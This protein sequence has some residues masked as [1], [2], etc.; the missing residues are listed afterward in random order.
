MEASPCA[1]IVSSHTASLL[2]SLNLQRQRSQFCDCVVRQ[3]QSPGQLYPA[4]RCVLAAS[5]PVLSSILSSSGALVELQAPCLTGSVLALLLDYIYTGTLPFSRIQQYYYSLLT[6]ACYLQMDELQEALRAWQKTKAKHVVSEVDKEVQKDQF[7]SAGTETWQKSTEEELQRRVEGKRKSSSPSSSSPHPY[8]E[9]V[10]VIRHSSRADMHQLAEVPP[11]QIPMGN[12]IR[13]T[14]SSKHHS[15]YLG[16][17]SVPQNKMCGE[18]IRGGKHKAELSFD[19]LPSKHQQLDWSDGHNVSTT[20]AAEETV[21]QDLRD[22]APLPV[23]MSDTGSG[24]QGEANDKQ[25]YSSRAPARVDRQKLHCNLYEARKDWF[26]TLRR[27]Q[28]S[29]HDTASARQENGSDR[30]K[31]ATAAVEN[32]PGRLIDFERRASLELSE[33]TEPRSTFTKPGDSNMSD[34]M[35]GV[36]G[37]SYHG[38]LHYHC[39]RHEDTRLLHRDSDQKPSHADYSNQSSDEE[40]EEEANTGRRSLRPHFAAGTPDQ[41]L[42]LD[43]SAKP[44]E[45]LVAY[46]HKS[47]DMAFCK[48]NSFGGG[49]SGQQDDPASVAGVEKKKS[50]TAARLGAKSFDEGKN[51]SWVGKTNLERPGDGAIQKAVPNPEEGES[52]SGILAPCSPPVFTRLCTSLNIIYLVCVH[53]SYSLGQHAKKYISPSV[54]TT[55]PNFPVFSV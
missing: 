21:S 55:P 26:P 42:L 8:C 30:E 13:M 37:Q 17:D 14:E 5:S 36:V 29:T 54:N 34:L 24:S 9:A 6:S 38:H 39:L 27:A 18:F 52:Q 43:I 32:V 16:G 28:S 49:V 1:Q 19:D 44:A 35:C 11:K 40:E 23:E 25:I 12:R 10:P 48:N 53:T 31:R 46:K 15:K 3:R 2:M 51:G 20:A 47:D 22:A 41:V 4:H 50:R 7:H 33:I 45:L